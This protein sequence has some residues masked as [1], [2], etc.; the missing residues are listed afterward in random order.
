MGIPAR[1]VEGYVCDN[2]EISTDKILKD[3]S[4]HAWVEIFV[5]GMG[6]MAVDVTPSNY[7]KIIREGI[8]N[9]YATKIT[10]MIQMTSKKLQQKLKLSRLPHPKKLLNQIL[11]TKLPVRHQVK[12]LL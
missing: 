2:L 7:R 12:L 5:K 1:Y 4:A 10:I 9:N 11:K 3:D 8:N 6:W